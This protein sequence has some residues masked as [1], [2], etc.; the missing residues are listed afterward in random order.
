L[1]RLAEIYEHDPARLNRAFTD[2]L[3]SS[4]MVLVPAF[5]LLLRLLY[6]RSRY[7]VHLVFSLN[8]HSFAFLALA[9]GIAVDLVGGQADASGGLGTGL[10]NLAIAVY[11]FVALRRLNGEGRILTILKMIGLLIGY[12]APLLV[13]M[14]AT[15]AVTAALA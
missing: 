2:R 13:T 12:M 4:V 6:R 8:L 9:I 1:T 5:A 15:L 11:T 14:L 3:A 10:A 7:V